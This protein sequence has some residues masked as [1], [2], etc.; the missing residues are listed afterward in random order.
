MFYD[1]FMSKRVSIKEIIKAF[2][3][4]E[5]NY[6]Q[7]ARLVGVSRL[8]VKRWVKYGRRYRG[9]VGWKKLKRK[10]TRPHNIHYRLSLEKQDEIVN[11]KLKEH[12]GAKKVKHILSVNASST[13]IHRLFKKK[14]LVTIQPN[15]R[16]PLFQN[17]KAMR[18]NNTKG[19]GYLQMDTKHVTPELSGLSFTVY[20]YAAID[21]V[22]RY[23]L[24]VLLPDIS[25]ESASLA[26]EFF[27]KWFPF[28]ITYIQTDNGLEY[29]SSFEKF[30]IRHNINHYYIHKNSPNEN[31]VIERSFRTDQDE[32]YYWLERQPEHIGQLNEW[33][34]KFINKYN[35][36][37]P[38]QS[39][40]YKTSIEIVNLYQMS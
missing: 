6:T 23:K 33:L 11:L 9:Y 4:T 14:N 19:L 36:W 27:L 7:A 17:G 35:T 22:S 39:L 40:D 32:F 13:T 29:Q 1:Q 15:F 38:H 21:I 28:Q 34:Q 8:T 31:A 18:P 16:R 3:E 26:L 2:K 10:S 24:A 12:L 5:G 25:D 37:R 20:E 30:C